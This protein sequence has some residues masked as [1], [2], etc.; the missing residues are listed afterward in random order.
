MMAEYLTHLLLWNMYRLHK[1]I[2]KVHPGCKNNQLVSIGLGND[3]GVKQATNHYLNQCWPE[4]ESMQ[5]SLNR[6]SKNNCLQQNQHPNDYNELYWKLKKIS[7]YLFNYILSQFSICKAYIQNSIIT[8]ITLI[9]QPSLVQLS[10]V[11]TL[12]LPQNSQISN[13]S[14]TFIGNKICDHSDVVGASPVGVAPTTP[15]FST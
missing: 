13:I 7:V 5:R 10:S 1:K 12:S 11:I 8:I 14:C 4:E 6:H 2:N 3:F 9:L 15:S